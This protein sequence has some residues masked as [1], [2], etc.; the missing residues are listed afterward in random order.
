MASVSGST[1]AFF[2][3]GNNT[4]TNVNLGLT[5]DGLTVPPPSTSAFNI[6][7]FT[8]SPSGGFSLASGYQASVYIQ[9]AS[10][11]AGGLG[12]ALP[13]NEVQAGSIGS[14]EMMLDGSFMLAD[15]TGSETIQVIGN[16]AGG[17]ADSV[18]GAFHDTIL[19]STNALNTQ[20]IDAS[21]VHT[22]PG[23]ETVVGGAGNT[24]V[25]AGSGDSI[26]GTGPLTVQGGGRNN[27]VITGGAGGL[28]AFDFGSGDS[29]SGVG[30]EVF[31]DDGYGAGGG[32]NTLTGG[33]G[34]LNFVKGNVGDTLIGGGGT[35]T[36]TFDGTLGSESIVGGS[37]F[38]VQIEGGLN[39]TISA[40]SGFATLIYANL[41][42]QTVIGDAAATSSRKLFSVQT[43]L[44]SAAPVPSTLP[45]VPVRRTRR[46]SGVP[47]TCLP[48]N[49]ALRTASSAAPR[50]RPRST[51]LWHRRQRYADRRQRH[52]DQHEYF[53]HHG[54]VGSQLG[55]HRGQ[56]RFDRRRD[57]DAGSQDQVRHQRRRDRQSVGAGER[58]GWRSGRQ[59]LRRPRRHSFGHRL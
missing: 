19:G 10:T 49:W 14:T 56:Q 45:V 55:H 44:S 9:G 54:G 48:S 57:R 16:G 6:E 26:T 8:A 4:G 3:N 31:I 32:H 13:N 1:L 37:G 15:Q 43:I 51:T 39:D 46:S 17:S 11:L 24:T 12:A 30:G 5:A 2:G 27:M 59:R 41:G 58:R 29:V 50:G 23:P 36:T 38:S 28:Y 20:Y 42:Q 53:R 35:G 25:V 34:P 18:I 52:R 22:N 40:G 47:E 7:V 21:G 33:S